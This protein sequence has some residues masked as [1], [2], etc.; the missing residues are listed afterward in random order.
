MDRKNNGILIAFEGIDGVGK[1]TQ[2]RLLAEFLRKQGC[3]VIETREPT[4]GPFGKKIRELYVDRGRCSLEEEFELF[5]QDRRRHVQEVIGP[6]LAAGS[7]VLTDRY[8]FSTAAY[9]GAAGLDPDEVLTQNSFAP[10]PDMVLL[11]TMKPE[12]ALA[13]IRE[14]R[15]EELNEFEQEE[16]L[17][18]V[19][20]LF[21]SFDDACIKRIDAASELITVQEEIQKAVNQLLLKKKLACMS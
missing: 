5:V 4:D 6:E 21:A 14:L 18:R 9:Q 12:D 11:L 15:G 1:S 2:L 17:S 13:R 16:Q 7:I 8:Y 20:K 3:T 19:A 10:K